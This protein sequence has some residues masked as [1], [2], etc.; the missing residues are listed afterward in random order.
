MA[1]TIVLNASNIVGKDNNTLVYAFPNSV[2]FPHHQIAIQ[3]VTMYYSWE[4]INSTTLANNFFTY[5]WKTLNVG[6]VNPTLV[7]I[8]NGL[9]EVTDI[10]H[11]LQFVMIQ[12]GQYLI[13]S[14]GQFVYFG[15]LVVNSSQY[16][17]QLNTYPIP[18]H[19]Q[20]N[21]GAAA[22]GGV[23]TGTGAYAGWTTPL[24]DPLVLNTFGWAGWNAQNYNPSFTFPANFAA[25]IGF[26]DGYSSPDQTGTELNFSVLSTRAP[27]V[28]PNSSIYFSISNINNQYAIPSSIIYSLSPAVAFGD[29]IRDIPPQYTWNNLIKGTYNELRLTILG[30]D[31]SPIVILDPNMTILLSIRDTKDLG[32]ADIVSQVQGGK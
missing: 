21:G 1:A 20:F 17:I 16:A 2:Q 13:N 4:N 29:Q 23:Y 7:N 18:T 11:Y 31:K 30:I 12:Q 9:Y 8:P 10:N 28:Q 24:A 32:L 26:A 14:A 3:N 22:V 6:Q 15:E 19:A 25:L 27:N 5:S